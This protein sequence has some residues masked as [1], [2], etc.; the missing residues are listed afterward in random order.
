M[1]HGDLTVSELYDVLSDRARR[2]LLWTMLDR[3][4]P[5]TV[6]VPEE[7]PRL[8]AG[9][10]ETRIRFVHVHLPKLVDTGLVRWDDDELRMGA[11][12]DGAE[13]ILTAARRE[14]RTTPLPGA[15]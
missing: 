6:R 1:E 11:A 15:V 4:H 8:D 5:G 7:L 3:G 2:R 13:P 9:R 10:R 14:E 12:F